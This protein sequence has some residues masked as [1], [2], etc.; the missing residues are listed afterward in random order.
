MGTINGAYFNHG[1]KFNNKGECK[2]FIID[3]SK[4]PERC[5]KCDNWTRIDEGEWGECRGFETVDQRN[6][7]TACWKYK[8]AKNK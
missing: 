1:V 5:Y 3:E 8:C 7:L 2:V 6:Q 4:N